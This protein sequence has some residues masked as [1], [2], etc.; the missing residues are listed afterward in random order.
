VS[1]VRRVLVGKIGLDGHDRGAKVVA[2]A[3]RDAGYEVVYTGLHQTVATVAQTACDEDVAAVGISILSGAHMT[4]LPALRRA[5]DEADLTDVPLF[6]GG[7][8]P[9]ADLDGLAEHG[10]EAV[11]PPGTSTETIV[12]WL[13]QRLA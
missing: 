7:V 5:L 6:A 13:G 10:V 4:L 11:F 9:A 1:R 12:S 3:L 8:I 2:R